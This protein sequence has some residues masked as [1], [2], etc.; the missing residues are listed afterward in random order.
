MNH[1]N[2]PSAKQRLKNS[3]S[4]N[5]MNASSAAKS[6]FGKSLNYTTQTIKMPQPNRKN[7][8]EP[9]HDHNVLDKLHQEGAERI[10]DH[11]FSFMG[12]NRLNLA[13]FLS[14]GFTSAASSVPIA[15]IPTI[16]MDVLSY[17]NEDGQDG[18]S[19]EASA[20]IFASTVA[21]YAVLG[22][23]FGKFLNGPLGDICGA[24]RIACLYAL[25]L[26]ISLMALSFGYS[27]FGVIA[28]CAAVEFFQSVQWPCIAVILAAHYGNTPSNEGAE[29]RKVS[30]SSKEVS[31]GSQQ[32]SRNKATGRYEKG[33]YI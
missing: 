20:S 4:P 10:S 31:N 21:T 29:Y 26:S 14:Y 33:I 11:H 22:T 32:A 15:L 18:Q 5:Y 23:A 2:T 8:H 13:L 24:R 30:P 3:N 27:G 25:M 16:A 28:C 6:W 19:L 9:I 12:V 1:R 17:D 7:P